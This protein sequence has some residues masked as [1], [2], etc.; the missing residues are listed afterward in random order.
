MKQLMLEMA[1]AN[2][3]INRLWIQVLSKIP[4]EDLDRPQGAFFDS[5]FGTLNHILLTDRIWVGRITGQL[6]PFQE[7]SERICETQEEFSR[8]RTRVDDVLLTMVS[9]EDNFSREIAYRTS[10]GQEYRQPM[11]QVLSHLFTHQHHHRG[12]VAQMCSEQNID[13]PAGG[14]LAYYRAIES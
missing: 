14:M 9:Q 6:F 11:F 7:L 10:A 12:Q 4:M 3:Y 5:I 13:V 1:E 8:E 2:Q